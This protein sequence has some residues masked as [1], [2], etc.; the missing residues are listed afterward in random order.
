MKKMIK[1]PLFL[2]IV[3]VVSTGLLAAVNAWT[4]PIIEQHQLEE[5]N[6]GYLTILGL[7]GLGTPNMPSHKT[8]STVATDETLSAKGLTK[9]TVVTNTSDDSIFGIV[10]DGSVAGY[11]G[12]SSPIVFQVG[13]VDGY[14]SG[15]NYLSHGETPSVGQAKVLDTLN[16]YLTGTDVALTDNVSASDDFAVD[17]AF[18]T[19][20]AGATVTKSK[21]VVAL[22]ASA[23]DYLASI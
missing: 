9:K 22:K 2:A 13:F 17:A 15:F 16:A 20:T 1:L 5:Q 8:I 6:A 10:Y 12:K 3:C 19:M 14:Y 4:A 7:D 21:L 18:L 11:G 23:V